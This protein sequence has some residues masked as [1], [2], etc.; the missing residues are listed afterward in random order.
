MSRVHPGVSRSSRRADASGRSL[1]SG[2]HQRSGCQCSDTSELATGLPQ[3]GIEALRIGGAFPSVTGAHI[4]GREDCRAAQG[5]KAGH[6][7]A[8][9]PKTRTERYGFIEDHH[10]EFTIQAMYNVLE[11]SCSGYYPWRQ[12]RPSAPVRQDEHLCETLRT[13]FEASSSSYGAQRLREDFINGGQ[14]VS[15]KRTRR[16]MKENGLQ[17]R[18]PT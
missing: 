15:R 8:R 9:F 13:Y 2:H 5:V 12:R 14:R 6:R 1:G 7:G 3:D 16:L 10:Q 17:V 4:A 18:P 11:V